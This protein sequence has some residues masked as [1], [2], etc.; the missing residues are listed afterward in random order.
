ML[1]LLLFLLFILLCFCFLFLFY[2]ILFLFCLFVVCCCCCCFLFVYC[3]VSAV[4][5]RVLYR[6]ILYWFRNNLNESLKHICNNLIPLAEV[7]TLRILQKGIVHPILGTSVK[8]WINYDLKK[9]KH[10]KCC[11]LICNTISHLPYNMQN[12]RIANIIRFY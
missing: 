8:K 3:G 7:P 11:D 5:F 4:N 10:R 12:V 6:D 1:L 9:K 2:F